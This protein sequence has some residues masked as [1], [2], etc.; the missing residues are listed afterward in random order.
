MD[1][2]F[3]GSRIHLIEVVNGELTLCGKKVTGSRWPIKP[4]HDNAE[5]CKVCI[6]KSEGK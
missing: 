6:K 1:A 4:E 5:V 2:V 3:Q